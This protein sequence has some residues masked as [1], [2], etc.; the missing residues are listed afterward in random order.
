ALMP[1]LVEQVTTL[2]ESTGSRVRLVGW[3]LGGFLA[4]EVSRDAPDVVERV[5]TLASPIVGGPKYTLAAG[6]YRR[7]GYDM[8]EMERMVAERDEVPLSVPVT[9]FYSKRDGVVAWQASID[10]TNEGVEHVEVSATHWS[11]GFIPEVL[12]PVAELM[13]TPDRAV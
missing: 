9:S 1:S 6:P 8:D 13:A 7:R 10:R 5:V 12:R 2:A 11:I 4:R 3:S